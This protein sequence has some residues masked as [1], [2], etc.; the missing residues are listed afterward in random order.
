[1]ADH[2][3]ADNGPSGVFDEGLQHERTAL[4]W[5]RTA[6]S[7]MVAGILLA[8]YG[9]DGAHFVFALFGLAETACGSVMLLWAA[10]HYDD[11]HGPLRSGQDVAHPTATN[12]V[13]IAAVLFTGCGVL[14]ALIVLFS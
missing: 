11:L 9:S 7:L 12:V 10:Q 1:M 3:G 14:Y 8:R 5:E 13:G 4:A 2:A 6:I